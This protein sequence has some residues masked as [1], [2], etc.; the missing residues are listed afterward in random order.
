M[1][2]L[3]PTTLSVTEAELKDF[4][5]RSR[6]RKYLRITGKTKAKSGALTH[7]P[8]DSSDDDLIKL[9]RDDLDASLPSERSLEA[10]QAFLH[11]GEDLTRMSVDDLERDVDDRSLARLRY[12]EGLP[13]L[14]PG[15]P[16]SDEESHVAGADQGYIAAV[17]NAALSRDP[18]VV[19]PPPFSS[20]PRVRTLRVS[21]SA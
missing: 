15:R 1:L 16:S 4:E 6:Y 17:R 20:R 21:W 10:D 7:L 12:G 8:K 18:T 3:R 19:L 2:R 11:L 14:G 13:P 5:L 9:P